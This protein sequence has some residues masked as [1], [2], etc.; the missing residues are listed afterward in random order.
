MLGVISDTFLTFEIQKCAY[1]GFFR[2]RTRFCE[3]SVYTYVNNFV[4]KQNI[5]GF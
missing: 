3:Q 1:D 2:F 4:Y 5:T